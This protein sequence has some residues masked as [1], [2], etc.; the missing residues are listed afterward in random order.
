MV[1]QGL[2]ALSSSKNF[3]SLRMEEASLTLAVT[4][5]AEGLPFNFTEVVAELTAEAAS[6]PPTPVTPGTSEDC[7][8]LDVFAPKSIFDNAGRGDGSAVLVWIYGGGYTGGSKA[9]SG[10]PSGLIARSMDAGGEGLIFVQLNYRLGALGWLAGPTLQGSGGVSNAALYDQRLALEWV[11]QHISKFGGDPNRVTIMGES[12]GGGSI[13]HQITAYGGLKPVPFQQAIPQSPAWLN[14]PSE[15]V[16]ENTTQ[17]FL[18]ILNVTS[19]EAARQASSEEVIAANTAQ[20]AAAPYGQYIYGPVA[21]GVFAPQVPGLLLNSGAFAHDVKVMVGHNADE[22]PYF[23][24]P[25]VTT[26]AELIAY[27]RT[28]YPGV[29]DS[30]AEYIVK[31]LYPANYGAGSPY[32]SPVNRTVF[33][34]SESIFTCTSQYLD[35]AF[36]N[37]T[38]AYEFEVPLAIHGWDVAYTFY[39]G[40]AGAEMVID[41]VAKAMQQYLVDFAVYG[42]PNGGPAGKALP[43][44]SEYGASAQLEALNYTGFKMMTDPTRNPRC[45]WW[46]KALYS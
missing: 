37:M 7:L 8:F 2:V 15:F 6:A 42:S 35:K 36:K 45:D 44:F 10:N 31:D 33:L 9:G 26:D 18:A 30:V 27:I 14:I 24:P 17:N 1:P 25:Y 5:Y 22:G 46:Q 11:Q 4:R 3:N 39:D 43:A 34:V 32:D 13:M 41:A 19:I 12:A 16:Q 21:D 40:V 29:Q 28:A 20:V 38:Y 23:T